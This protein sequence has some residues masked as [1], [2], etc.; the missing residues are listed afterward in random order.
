MWG[1]PDRE[2]EWLRQAIELQRYRPTNDANDLVLHRQAARVVASAAELPLTVRDS[3]LSNAKRSIEGMMGFVSSPDARQGIQLKSSVE[4]SRY[5]YCVAGIVGELLTE[6]FL[7]Y[8]PSLEEAGDELRS[9][10]TKFGEALQLVNILKDAEIDA[11]EHR[12]FIPDDVSR[13]QL[14]DLACD[15]LESANEYIDILRENDAE[16][17]IIRFTQLPVSLA[18][19][20]LDLVRK[21][22]SG[23]KVSR[24]E[25]ARIVAELDS[26]A[27]ANLCSSAREQPAAGSGNR[28]K[29]NRS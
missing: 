4:L 10:A 22:G 14:F 11:R 17:G 23:A 8:Q 28:R 3:I 18:S 26:D 12:R 13:D 24:E 19:L 1:S 2:S 15:R 7:I 6:L 16:T 20:T 5:C 27:S 25:V 9:R 21:D 29:V